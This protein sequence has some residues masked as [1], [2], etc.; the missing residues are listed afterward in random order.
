MTSK[1]PSLTALWAG[2]QVLG[3]GRDA[4]P[5]TSICP[6]GGSG[7][8]DRTAFRLNL[9][10]HD[11]GVA[12]RHVVENQRW[13]VA[14]SLAFGLATPTRLTLSYFKLKQ[15]NISD[16]GIPWVP[17]TNNALADYRDKPAPVPRNTFYGFRDRDT[18][19]PTRY[20]H[21]EVR[22]RFRGCGSVPQPVPLRAAG[23]NSIATPPRFGSN[24]STAINRELRSWVAKTRSAI[25]RPT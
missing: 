20:R 14:P 3:N 13:G 10:A 2:R 23:R 24:D 7:L 9:L 1:G 18:E 22:T 4:A 11:S 15:D 8:G 16:Y 21:H 19:V 25:T 5:A 17:A 6:S 12:G